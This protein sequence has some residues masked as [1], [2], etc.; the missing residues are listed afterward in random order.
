V[1]ER[2]LRIVTNH[3]PRDVVEAWELTDEERADFDY[4]D[5]G[6]IERGEDSASFFRYKGHTYDLSE[7]QTTYGLPNPLREWHGVLN[8]SFFSGIVVRYTMDAYGTLGEQVVV[9]TFYA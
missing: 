9:G 6:A 2:E 8:D 1:S 7:F 5:F 3:V 4:I